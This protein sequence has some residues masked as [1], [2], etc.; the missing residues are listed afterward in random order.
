MFKEMTQAYADFCKSAEE[1]IDKQKAKS[2]IINSNSTCKDLNKQ[3]KQNK[4]KDNK[5]K[6]YR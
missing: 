1:F 3:N 4:I 2:K 5:K 6:G